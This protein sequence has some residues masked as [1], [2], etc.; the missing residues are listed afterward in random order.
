[1]KKSSK[2]PPTS[3]MAWRAWPSD[4]TIRALD[5]LTKFGFQGRKAAAAETKAVYLKTRM[6]MFG[7]LAAALL[8]GIGLAVVITRHL[9]AQLGGEPGTAAAVAKAVA[10]AD[11]TTAIRL[12]AGDTHSLMAILA[13]MQ[14]SLAATVTNVRQ[15]SEN[16]ATASAQIA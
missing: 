1:V 8:F 3:A 7:L 13:A 11:L 10:G 14:R 16:V 6:L 2:M 9:I 5:A 12:K 4:T 15:G